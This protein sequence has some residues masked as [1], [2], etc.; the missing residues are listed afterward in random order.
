MRVSQYHYHDSEWFPSLPKGDPSQLLLSFGGREFLQDDNIIAALKSGFPQAENIGCTTSGEI[1]STEVYDD[2][3]VVTA[4]SMD[5]TP[6]VVK[7]VNASAYA[8]SFAAGIA[9][10][11]QLEKAGLK[12]VLL[13]ADGQKVNG[14]ELVAGVTQGLPKGLLI[15]GGMAGDGERFEE[16]IVWHNDR[17]RA[18]EIVLCGFYGDALRVGHGT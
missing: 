3:L 9:L 4:I 13:I 16:T 12:Y 17:V 5:H 11:D 7:S 8:N 14:T 18:G 15:T 2:S 10:S 1:L 6:I